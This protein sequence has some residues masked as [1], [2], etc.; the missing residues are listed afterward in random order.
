MLYAVQCECGQTLEVPA[1]MAGGR[2]TC[3]CG[4]EMLVPSLSKLKG[5]SGGS[6]MSA[7]I[8]L[9]EM[10]RRG[11]LPQETK[12]LLCRQPT[13]AVAY[14]WTTCERPQ[15]EQEHGWFHYMMRFLRLDLLGLARD[16][17]H[18]EGDTV[19]GRDLQYR[20]PLRVC[21]DCTAQLR[22]A[23]L[24]KETLL[25]VPVYAE[26]LDKYPHADVS[27]DLGLAGIARREEK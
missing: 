18:N 23:R 13:D 25:D 22:D 21:P 26:L 8:R 5:Q 27:L 4:R 11:T 12:C 9:D 24:L 15:V 7:E 3:E 2:V 1:T 14:C 6:A 20:L 16:M 10:L 19:H 17:G